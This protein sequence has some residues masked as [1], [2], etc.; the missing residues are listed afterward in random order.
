MSMTTAE[1]LSNPP[2][3]RAQRAPE[4]TTSW[5]LFRTAAEDPLG[6]AFGD[7]GQQDRRDHE[8]GGRGGGQDVNV[9]VR[10]EF[11][12]GVFHPGFSSVV[13]QQ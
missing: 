8:D 6:E 10:L 11:A 3:T 4:R 2:A 5:W 1:M 7:E 13:A 9:R 12:R